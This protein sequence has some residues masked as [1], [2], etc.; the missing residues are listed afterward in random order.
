[1]QSFDIYNIQGHLIPQ[2][3]SMLCEHALTSYIP[4]PNNYFHDSLDLINL[5]CTHFLS[6]VF[7]SG[8]GTIMCVGAIQKQSHIFK[9]CLVT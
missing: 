4:V 8:Y 5:C 1:M 2:F 7:S 6:S 9:M 3:H